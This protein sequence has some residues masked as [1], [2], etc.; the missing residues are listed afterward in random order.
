MPLQST[1]RAH[2]QRSEGLSCGPGCS[3]R[4]VKARSV[5]GGRGDG[6][7]ACATRPLASWRR[8]PPLPHASRGLRNVS[9]DRR[10]TRTCPSFSV[11]S[12]RKRTAVCSSAHNGPR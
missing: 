8:G 6:R 11:S 2:A 7:A 10:P 12:A 4:A 9:G 5:P 3:E 1:R